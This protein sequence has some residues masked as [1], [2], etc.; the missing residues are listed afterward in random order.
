[1]SDTGIGIAEANR[2]RIFDPFF[3]TKEVGRGTGQGLAISHAVIAEKHG[4]EISFKTETGKGT[5][6]LIQ[7][8]L[9]EKST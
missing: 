9:E 6:F 3:T 1:V 4:G 5:T 8:P 2:G 7:L